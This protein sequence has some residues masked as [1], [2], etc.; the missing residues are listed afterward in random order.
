MDQ[1][2]ER[3]RKALDGQLSRMEP[4]ELDRASRRRLET[5][6]QK[7]D[8][9]GRG[10]ADDSKFFAAN[11][12]RNFRMRLATPCEIEATQIMSNKGRP[13]WLPDDTVWWTVVWQI[14][15]GVRK[16]CQVYAPVPLGS[17]NGIPEQVAQEIFERFAE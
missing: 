5:L 16:R 15:P 4:V 2:I 9:R 17:V 14:T 1:D 11:P 3:I 13:L 10:S 8:R 7:D 6:L 12:Q